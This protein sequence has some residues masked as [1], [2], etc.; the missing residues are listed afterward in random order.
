MK[1]KQVARI[2][3]CVKQAHSMLL[4]SLSINNRYYQVYKIL[5]QEIIV[6][7]YFIFS[8]RLIVNY[9]IIREFLKIPT[10]EFFECFTCRNWV[11]YSWCN[12]TRTI[13]SFRT[14]KKKYQFL[15]I[16]ALKFHVYNNHF[17]Q[18]NLINYNIFRICHNKKGKDY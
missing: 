4:L 7:M 6:K 9:S 2:F 18:M 14:T 11:L 17:A 15:F 1:Q 10:I 3:F 5:L 16:T 12:S 13:K 8:I